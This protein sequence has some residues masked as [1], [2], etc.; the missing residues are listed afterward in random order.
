MLSTHK[1]IQLYKSFTTGCAEM[2]RHH[3]RLRYNYMSSC[4]LQM[5]DHLRLVKPFL[6]YY[7]L[8]TFSVSRLA[9]GMGGGLCK[10]QAGG[11]FLFKKKK[12]ERSE[13]GGE[14][15]VNGVYTLY[16]IN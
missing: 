3:Y 13:E 5:L 9:P 14:N 6:Y 2:N 7:H 10:A 4:A 12:F 11:L 8:L 1:I 16:D 15:E